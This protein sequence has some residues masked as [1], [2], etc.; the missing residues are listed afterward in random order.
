ML[1]VSVNGYYDEYDQQIE[2]IAR[3]ISVGARQTNQRRGEYLF[4]LLPQDAMMNVAWSDMD[5][6]YD[7]LSF[8]ETIEWI[9]NHLMIRD[10]E[11]VGVF[12]GRNVIWEM[13]S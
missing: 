6:Y 7:I 1:V 13:E 2:A 4:N 8:K 5:P 9:H 10:Y 3:S 12:D 11:I